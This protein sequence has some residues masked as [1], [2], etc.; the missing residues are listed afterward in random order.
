VYKA[1]CPNEIKEFG[2]GYEEENAMAQ[3]E[4]EHNIDKIEAEI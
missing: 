3:S 2:H 4:F 1:H